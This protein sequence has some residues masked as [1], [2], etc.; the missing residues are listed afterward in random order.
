MWSI[1]VL[2]TAEKHAL[3]W[4]KSVRSIFDSLV[5]TKQ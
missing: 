1:F 4:R 3:R 5:V 2:S